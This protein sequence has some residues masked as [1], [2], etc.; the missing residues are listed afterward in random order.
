MLY[1]YLSLYNFFIFLKLMIAFK[2]ICII[3][4]ESKFSY[5]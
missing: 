5:I 3:V 2:I 4:F 1:D